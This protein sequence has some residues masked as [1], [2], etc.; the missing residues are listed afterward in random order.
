MRE[1]EEIIKCVEMLM[2]KDVFEYAKVF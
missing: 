2:Q 1:L